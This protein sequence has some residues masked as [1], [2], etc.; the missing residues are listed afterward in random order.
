MLSIDQRRQMLFAGGSQGSSN[1][2]NGSQQ[3]PMQPAVMP[4][5]PQAPQAGVLSSMAT[6]PTAQFGQ[7][8]Q[9]GQIGQ[10]FGQPP[11]QPAPPVAQASFREIDPNLRT[12]QSNETVRGQL[13]GILSS[14]S[15]L[16]AQARA[17]AAEQMQS[18]GLLNSSMALQAGE[19]AVLDKALQIATPDAATYAAAAA[20]NQDAINRIAIANQGEFGQTSRSN[21]G[22]TNDR[23]NIVVNNDA[24]MARTNVQ[25]RGSMDRLQVSERGATDR[26]NISEAGQNRRSDAQNS[27]QMAVTRM[28][29]ETSMA[30]AGMN[31]QTQIEVAGIQ[32]D[33]NIAL[34][35]MSAANARTLESSRAA[36]T[37]YER[38]V[39]RITDIMT[40]PDLDGPT[41]ARLIE[42]QRT[43]MERGLDLAGRA[44][45]LN[46]E[47]V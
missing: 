10:T 39:E 16:L 35:E 32:R 45:D 40:N 4:F 24:A 11:G 2:Y 36:N 20:G 31:R 26:L 6:Q 47:V 19:G 7:S 41:R 43:M 27:T 44:Q 21:A 17:R 30:T 38:G 9:V 23:G 15:P 37:L 5:R 22:F 14:D 46:L 29:N 34:N 25:E 8:G 1:M 28:N 3:R 33:T 42:N 18:R 12:V 13:D